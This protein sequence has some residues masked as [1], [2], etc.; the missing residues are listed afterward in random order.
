MEVLHEIYFGKQSQLLKLE[1][2]FTK[3]R[4]KYNGSEV[5]GNL[6]V[7][8]DL[9]KDPINNIIADTISSLFGFYETL[10]TYSN[11]KKFNA[12]TVPFPVDKDGNVYDGN[13]NKVSEKKFMEKAIIVTNKGIKY[14]K[15]IFKVNFLVCVNTGLI[16]TDL[17]SVQEIVSVLLH[18]IG[19]SFSKALIEYRI[20]ND[21]MDETFADHFVAMYG[22][23]PDY[24]RAMDIFS[25]PK[26]GNIEDKFTDV[27]IVN[28]FLGV[29]KVW[30]QFKYR[31]TRE[32]PHPSFLLRMKSQLD[33]LE[34]DLKNTPNLTPTMRKEIKKQIDE[35]KSRIDSSFNYTDTG[36]NRVVSYYYK[37]LEPR[38]A[39]ERDMY[40]HTNRYVNPEIINSRLRKL[41]KGKG[42]R[43]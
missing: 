14:D 34:S 39:V 12:Y 22:Y 1:D 2:L 20:M 27:P 32:D 25:R 41:Y 3:I 11:R 21:R 24:V 10:F 18:E 6:K 5:L 43:K 13:E 15:S 4:G 26:Y 29:S 37:N 40:S 23:G 33:Q 30:K 16:F 35:C 7:Y 9:L 17:L 19:H 36:S 28:L 38:L 8:R 42:R 31:V